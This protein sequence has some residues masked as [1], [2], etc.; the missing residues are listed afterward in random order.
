MSWR[1]LKFV[2]SRRR[3]GQA[4]HLENMIVKEEMLMMRTKPNFLQQ[5]KLNIKQNTKLKS[6]QQSWLKESNR[7]ESK[8]KN[9]FYNGRER[10][11]DYCATNSNSKHHATIAI[12]TLQQLHVDQLERVTMTNL[13]QLL[14]KCQKKSLCVAMIIYSSKACGISIGPEI[15]F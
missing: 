8:K 15:L 6:K 11:L 2:R 14:C 10:G 7:R 13:R 12:Q 3:R 4:L 5:K 1:P 9:N